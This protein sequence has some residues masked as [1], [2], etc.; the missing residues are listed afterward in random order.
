MLPDKER[1][2]FDEL[3]HEAIESLPDHL[4]ILLEEVPLIADD[5]PD[6]DLVT[7]LLR[8]Y[9][10]PDTPDDREEFARTLCGLHSG[11][12]LTE[13]SVDLPPELPTDIRLFREGILNTA[14]GWSNDDDEQDLYDEIWITL[15]HEMGHHFG[16]DEDD[17]ASL[18]YD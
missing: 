4:R 9:D 15:L 16:L 8:E 7:T 6:D 17:L 11:I 3:L 18:G 5:R 12:A 1:K 2:R 14:G 13:Q 10:E